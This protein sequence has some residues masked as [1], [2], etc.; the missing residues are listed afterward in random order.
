MIYWDDF[1]V[2]HGGNGLY[3][4]PSWI[5]RPEQVIGVRGFPL[6]SG[7]PSSDNDYRTNERGSV[8]LTW[9]FER[10]DKRA[11]SPLYINVDCG[12][13]RPFIYALRPLPA[14]TSDTGTTVADLD[15]VVFWAAEYLEAENAQEKSRVL[16]TLRSLYFV[17]P[18]MTFPRR[19]GA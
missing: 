4:L 1:Q 19:V 17:R 11:N 10:A 18:T 12:G 7:G 15:D 6:G 13:Y 5:T 14:L 3:P 2:W 16:K 8:P 9:D